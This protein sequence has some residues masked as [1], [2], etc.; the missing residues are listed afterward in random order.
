MSM[1]DQ[2]ISPVDSPR[3]FSEIPGLWLRLGQMT[4]AF[5]AA[6]YP[7]TSAANTIYGVL[8]YTAISTF[9][10]II[11]S[12]LGGIISYFTST[13]ATQSAGLATVIGSMT[14]F[15]CCF[16]LLVTPIAFYLNNGITFVGAQIFGGRGSFNSQAYLSSLFVAPLGFIASLGSFLSLVPSVGTYLFSAVLFGV[17]IYHVI[18]TIRSF[19]VVHELSAGRAAA[20]VLLPMAFILIPICI[21]AVLMLMGPAIGNVF[22]EINAQLGTPSP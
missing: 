11:Q 21:I 5:F 2:P 10:A 8:T 1:E 18:L 16:G 3:P 4:E 7:R 9:L 12:L 17:T 20:A 15:V 6:E 13:T 19:K 22:S 14:V